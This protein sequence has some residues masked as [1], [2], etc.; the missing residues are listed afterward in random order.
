VCRSCDDKCIPGPSPVVDISWDLEYA[1]PQAE[2][3]CSTNDGVFTEFERELIQERTLAGLASARIDGKRIGRPNKV[4]PEI[5]STVSKPI[6]NQAERARESVRPLSVGLQGD[7]SSRTHAGESL[8]RQYS[9]ACFFVS[10]R[11]LM[12]PFASRSADTSNRKVERSA[13]GCHGMGTE[14]IIQLR[15][16]LRCC[17]TRLL[18][19][20]READLLAVHWCS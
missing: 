1:R 7:R 15:D 19:C 14:R 11:L 10:S 2:K 12:Q 3:P 5:E 9:A 18:P 17:S 20:L 6:K 4:A 8:S 16:L 13:P